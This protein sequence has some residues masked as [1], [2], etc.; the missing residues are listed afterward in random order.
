[1]F[2]QDTLWYTPH[3]CFAIFISIQDKRVHGAIVDLDP[4]GIIQR[5]SSDVH[6][7]EPRL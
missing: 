6:I 1:M 5:D 3:S 4:A 7:D 2:T